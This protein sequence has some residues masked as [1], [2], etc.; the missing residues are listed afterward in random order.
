MKIVTYKNIV[1]V[2][3]SFRTIILRW[4]HCYLCHP[5]EVRIHT[6]LAST[7]YWE[8]MEDKSRQ[9]V[10]QCPTCQRFKKNNKN[11]KYNKIPPKN[12]ELIPLDTVSI[13]LVGPHTK[14]TRKAM[15]DSL[16]L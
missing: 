15:S 6:A 5:D 3:K 7:L 8:K 9:F 4:H 16:M 11:N 2:P 14:L 1:Y 13:D 10:K 12:V